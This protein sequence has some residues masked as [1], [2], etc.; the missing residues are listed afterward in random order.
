MADSPIQFQRPSLTAMLK[1][2][3]E[4]GPAAVGVVGI[5][6]GKDGHGTFMISGF[7]GQCDSFTVA[8]MLDWIKADL[9]RDIT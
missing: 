6:L 1:E 4:R 9:M 7:T 3:Q 2:I 5:I 8:G